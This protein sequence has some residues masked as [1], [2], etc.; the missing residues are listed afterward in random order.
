MRLQGRS[1]PDASLGRDP[2]PEGEVADDPAPADDTGR[3]K[4]PAQR[5]F[6]SGQDWLSPYENRAESVFQWGI[7]FEDMLPN[8]MESGWYPM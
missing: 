8:S 2:Y 4:G 6:H 5:L 3:T 1:E 7:N